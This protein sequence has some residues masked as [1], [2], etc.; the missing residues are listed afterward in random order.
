ME[1]F[2]I[3]ESGYTGF[4]LLNPQQRLQGAAAIAISDEDAGR[5]I[6]EHFPRCKASELKY[7]ALSRRPSSRPHLLELLRDLLQSFKCVTHVLDKRYMLILMFC[8]YAVEPWYYERGVNFYA[9][10]QN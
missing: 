5:L 2:R 1:C 9:D 8:D 10:G 4:D 7:R 3:D 6:K